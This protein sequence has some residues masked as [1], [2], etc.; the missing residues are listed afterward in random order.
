MNFYS[1]PDGANFKACSMQLAPSEERKEKEGK[2][3]KK[4]MRVL[5]RPL[6]QQACCPNVSRGSRG[7]VVASPSPVVGL[8]ASGSDNVAQTLTANYQR[9][10]I[11]MQEV[12]FNYIH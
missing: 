6:S 12:A 9:L 5:P 7:V 4:N 2:R 10:M 3:K 11:V 1:N 8:S